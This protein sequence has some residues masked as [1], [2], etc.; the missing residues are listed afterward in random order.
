METEAQR[1]GVTHL[2]LGTSKAGADSDLRTREDRAGSTG[3]P[4]TEGADVESVLHP[5]GTTG[6]P[7]GA[8]PHQSRDAGPQAVSAER[9]RDG[10]WGQPTTYGR[11]RDSFSQGGRGLRGHPPFL[12]VSGEGC[13]ASSRFLCTPHPAPPLQ[14]SWQLPSMK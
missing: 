8:E 2:R 7:R 5:R 13:P 3:E 6:A 10:L 1:G 14:Q 4:Q 11:N 9:S 12:S